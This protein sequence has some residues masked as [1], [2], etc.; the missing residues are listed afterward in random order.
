MAYRSF[1]AVSLCR[2]LNKDHE[3]RIFLNRLADIVNDE[4]SVPRILKNSPPYFENRCKIFR[5]NGPS[6]SNTIG[7]WHWTASPNQKNLETDYIKS[8]YQEKY[9]AIRLLSI[10]GVASDEQ[11]IGK[12]KQGIYGRTYSCDTIF[13]Y[14][15]RNELYRGAFCEHNDLCESEE[16]ISLSGKLYSLPF[17]EIEEKKTISI[18]SELCFL[19]TLSLENPVSY[20]PTGNT[21][22]LIK[23]LFLARLTS[24]NFKTII[25]GT[26]AEWR[27]CKELL[28]KLC[29]GSLYADV[30]A[31]LHCSEAEAKKLVSTFIEEA[32]RQ[33]DQGALDVNLL[34]EIATHHDRLRAQCEADSE[35]AA[36]KEEAAQI[37]SKIQAEKTAAAKAYNILNQEIA[38]AGQ[39]RDAVFEEIRSAQAE[40]DRLCAEIKRNE[41]LGNDTVQATRAKIAAAQKDMAGFIADLSMFMPQE[42]DKTAGKNNLPWKYSCTTASAYSEKECFTNESWEDEFDTLC[43]NLSAYVPDNN[44]R[45]LLTAYLYSAFVNHMPILALG[46][47]GQELTDALSL[48]IYGKKPGLLVL[49]SGC[50]PALPDAI[51]R[52]DEKMLSIQNMFHHGWSDSL[53]QAFARLDKQIVWTHP[54]AEDLLAEPQGLYNYVLPLF[55]ECFLETAPAC[56]LQPGKRSESFMEYTPSTK[57]PRLHL[58][59]FRELRL[60]KWLL[61]RLEKVLSD[62]QNMLDADN[63]N[64]D[65]E[66]LFGLLP[67]AV[68]SGKSDLLKDTLENEG[69]LSS[70]SKSIAAR[71]IEE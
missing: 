58:K 49:G 7:V 26:K 18:D 16:K 45:K 13:C 8:F 48:S 71:Y 14:T 34:A 22:D 64:N 24:R 67:L 28:E 3:E 30:E 62:A 69:T 4:L 47:C 38:R 15:L 21:N 32:S 29:S 60:S 46:P 66:F 42:S 2:V 27:K 19:K 56:S 31:N 50:D 70:D 41:T 23:E 11:L 1:E 33:L 65:I 6:E 25:G 10:P 55:N 17:Y 53:P 35:L 44:L 5:N 51:A 12:L 39:Q 37:R 36:V 61:T 68:L 43:A 40:L 57:K 59:A 52:F 9:R 54:Y 20:L 63:A